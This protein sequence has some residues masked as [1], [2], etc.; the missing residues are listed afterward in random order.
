MFMA[1]LLLVSCVSS[2]LFRQGASGER[3]AVISAGGIS[4]VEV[5]KRIDF[6]PGSVIA[7][8]NAGETVL[9][10]KRNAAAALV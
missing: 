7:V 2:G 6:T 5:Y 1:V 4:R 8:I 10:L 9:V 3:T